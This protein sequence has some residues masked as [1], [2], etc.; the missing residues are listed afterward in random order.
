MDLP[1]AVPPEPVSAKV[2]S[3]AV[4]EINQQIWKA[5]ASLDVRTEEKAMEDVQLSTG[6]DEFS[7]VD[8]YEIFTSA[9]LAM[10]SF[11]LRKYHDYIPLNSRTLLSPAA[12]MSTTPGSS[13]FDGSSEHCGDSALVTLH[14]RLT[15]LGTL[16]VAFSVTSSEFHRLKTRDDNGW[17]R[18]A[19]TEVTLAPGGQ[20]AIYKGSAASNAGTT[21]P[22]RPTGSERT[23]ARVQ[24][25][26][27]LVEGRWKARV[28]SWLA[29]QGIQLHET[30]D[31]LWLHVQIQSSSAAYAEDGILATEMNSDRSEALQVLWPSEL[32]YTRVDTPPNYP[33]AGPDRS[34][35]LTEDADPLSFA[36][37]WFKS[38]S[39]RDNQLEAARSARRDYELLARHSKISETAMLDENSMDEPY[40]RVVN[41]LDLHAAGTVYPT[42]PD[43]THAQGITGA[44]SSNEIGLTP[45]NGDVGNLDPSASVGVTKSARVDEGGSD[46]D[47]RRRSDASQIAMLSAAYDASNV[48]MFVDMDGDMF[49]TSGVTEADFSFFDGPD[50]DDSGDRLF[51]SVDA[52]SRL[53]PSSLVDS[54]A[55]PAPGADFPTLLARESKSPSHHGPSPGIAMERYGQTAESVDYAHLVYQ[56]AALSIE[57]DID[58]KQDI[59]S[60]MNRADKGNGDAEGHGF[61][62]P[63]LSPLSVRKKLLPKLEDPL[64]NGLD[65]TANKTIAKENT[66]NLDVQEGVF[67]RVTFASAIDSSDQKYRP[68][69]HFSKVLQDFQDNAHRESRARESHIPSIGFPTSR[70]T[71]RAD[72]AAS[73]SNTSIQDEG[74]DLDSDAVSEY[75]KGQGGS[76]FGSEVSNNGDVDYMALAEHPSLIAGVKRKRDSSSGDPSVGVVTPR[77]IHQPLISGCETQIRLPSLSRFLPSPSARPMARLGPHLGKDMRKAVGLSDD[78]YIRVAQILTDQVISSSLRFY[79]HLTTLNNRVRQSPLMSA[80]NVDRATIGEVVRSIFPTSSPCDLESYAAIEETISEPPTNTRAINKPHRRAKT[81]GERPGSPEGDIFRLSPPHVRVQRAETPLEVLTPALPFWE[82][83][84]LG[85]VNGAKDVRAFCI[86]PPM[87]GLEDAAESF[88]EGLG[89]AYESCKL[90]SHTR[91]GYLGNSRVGVVPIAADDA[92]TSLEDTMEKIIAACEELGNATSHLLSARLTP[93]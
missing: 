52:T 90:G 28:Q 47:E 32:C 68:E 8:L 86:C 87:Q 56:E 13:D 33:N 34:Q 31:P 53:D 15:N 41:Y 39:I 17:L 50:L 12:I 43:G 49:G 44:H 73:I 83:L 72:A 29:G 71:S 23:C 57:A 45:D 58:A 37:D 3:R 38:K 81:G 27:T 84:G 89:S 1:S 85:P 14:V 65:F 46:S 80:G 75:D 2:N 63:P 36:E 67:G 40:I 4:K 66:G 5:N 78:D 92:H 76:V 10:F 18:L 88:L 51:S 91:G 22:E 16:I 93:R 30:R 21:L 61:P 82:T 48:D 69:G 62:S 11:H 35:A 6:D 20:R 7:T 54:V 19:C 26:E 79:G 25:R 60:I 77:K 42:P 9:V 24:S 64:S 55:Q 59:P 70:R 74:S